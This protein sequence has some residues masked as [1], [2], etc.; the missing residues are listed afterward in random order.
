MNL[1]ISGPTPLPP[2]VR[3]A[4]TRQMVSHRSESFRA[5]IRAILP[6]LMPLFGTHEPPL[7]FTASGTGG[8]EAALLNTLEHGQRVLAVRAGMFGDRFAEIA[9]HVGLEVTDLEVPWGRAVSPDDLRRVLRKDERFDAVLLTHNESSTGVLNPLEQVAKV[10]REESDALLLVDAVSSAG[11]IPIEMDLWGVDVI[12]TASQKALMSPPGL[13]ILAAGDRALQAAEKGSSSYYFDFNKMREAVAEGTT[14]YTPAV[15][16]LYGLEAALRLIEKEGLDNV[17]RRH[18]R[19][20][21]KCRTGLEALGMECFAADGAASPTITS[22]LLPEDSSATKVRDRLESEH[23][24]FI[25]Q[26]RKEYKERMLRI[27]HMG[28]VG[29]EEIDGLLGAFRSV[30]KQL[31]PG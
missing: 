22:V 12:V 14:T 26:G 27:G 29:D 17:Y 3:K 25:A 28:W 13:A 6:R 11:G 20:A 1:R 2:E 21:V 18:E 16:T 9:R 8:M 7:L 24:V 4:V 19:L 5:C 31:Q 15:S 23:G 30:L 10:V